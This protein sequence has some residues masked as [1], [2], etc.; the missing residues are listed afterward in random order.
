[1]PKDKCIVCGKP[2]VGRFCYKHICEV[3][4]RSQRLYQ[5]DRKAW[6]AEIDQANAQ[7][8]APKRDKSP[9]KP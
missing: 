4:E 9:A 6:K 7:K 1:M 3:L 2:C 8:H 5:T